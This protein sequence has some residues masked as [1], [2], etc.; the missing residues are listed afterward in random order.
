MRP[1]RSALDSRHDSVDARRSATPNGRYARTRIS[2]IKG[3]DAGLVLTA[4]GKLLVIGT[5]PDSDLVLSDDTVSRRHCEVELTETGFRVRDVGST[6]GVRSGGAR[7]YD[8]A[9]ESQVEVALG[10]TLLS[11]SPLSRLKTAKQITA[12][13]RRPARRLAEDARVVRRATRFAPPPECAHRR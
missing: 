5:A 10:E 1:S 13:L 4:A 6:N 2:V 8:A 7:I 11:L 12:R 9:F 3:P